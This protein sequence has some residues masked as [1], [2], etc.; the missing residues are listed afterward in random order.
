MSVFFFLS[1]FGVLLAPTSRSRAFIQMLAQREIKPALAILLPGTEPE[2]VDAP[3][4]VPFYEGAGVFTFYPG[5]SLRTTLDR[6]NVPYIVAPTSDVN[7]PEFITFIKSTAPTF[8]LYSGMPGCL[9]RAEIFQ[10]SGKRFLHAHGGVA[11]RYSGSTAFYYSLL[12][13]GT[14]GATV[15]W[16]EEGLDTGDV[17]HITEAPAHKGLDIDHI[18]DPV[19]RAEAMAAAIER[20]CRDPAHHE[21]Q[22]HENRVTYHIIHPVLK[23]LALKKIR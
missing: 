16:M 22:S 14:I 12:E 3:V 13:R 23:H 21:K 17:I 7:A 6:L 5:E 10:H 20:L 9:L 19:I 1:D 2:G 18:Q 8:F 4:T 11:P 15:F